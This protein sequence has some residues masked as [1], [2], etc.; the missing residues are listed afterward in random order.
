MSNSSPLPITFWCPCS[1][2]YTV[3]PGGLERCPGCSTWA[4]Y[5]V[6]PDGSHVAFTPPPLPLADF[7]LEVLD[8]RIA[9]ALAEA[10]KYVRPPYPTTPEVTGLPE[11]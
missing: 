6:A 9:S 7:A 1:M 5:T 8:D 3:A 2:T 10:H 4:V 11:K